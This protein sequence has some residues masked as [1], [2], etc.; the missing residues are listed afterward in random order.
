MD[1]PLRL[2]DAA[3]WEAWL[4]VSHGASAGVWLQLAKRGT[5]GLTYADALEVALC[6]GWIDAQKKGLDGS[7]W[8]QRFTPRRER[9]RWSKI[10]RAS[11]EQLVKGARMR[12]A[13]LA[14]IARARADGRWDAAYDPPSTA[15]VPDDLAA[16]LAADPAA[17][18]FFDRLDGA[19]RYA[20]LYRIQEA[21]RAE[22]RARRIAGFVTMLAE[23]RTVH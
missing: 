6:F 22:T 16:A 18:A 7:W 21:K 5:A 20:I 2:A 17:S 10:N 9:S 23:G 3:A 13:G 4:D 8:L 15:T 19:N 11:A 14:E 1:T 12:P